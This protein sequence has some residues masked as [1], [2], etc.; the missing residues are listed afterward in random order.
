MYIWQKSDGHV[1]KSTIFLSI[2]NRL[3]SSY[4][5]FRHEE[6]FKCSNS[7]G[8]YSGRKR[9]TWVKV[10]SLHGA[11]FRR[12]GSCVSR[13]HH[14]I[15]FAKTIGRHVQKYSWTPPHSFLVITIPEGY[16]IDSKTVPRLVKERIVISPYFQ[17]QMI[18]GR[19]EILKATG[20]VNSILFTVCTEMVP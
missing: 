17:N 18:W 20:V 16:L 19:L 2:F 13:L 11:W 7:F 5:Q 9:L 4:H 8:S 6:C 10:S 3:K 12:T 1:H 14:R 15:C